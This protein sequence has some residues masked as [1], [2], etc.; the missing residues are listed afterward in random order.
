MKERTLPRKP[1]ILSES[2]ERRLGTYGLAASAAGVTA[3]ALAVPAADAKIV[4]TQT[5]VQLQDNQPLALDFNHDGKTDFFLLFKGPRGSVGGFYYEYLAACHRPITATHGYECL[6]SAS[7]TYNPLNGIRV[8]KTGFFTANAILAGKG[9]QKGE[10]FKDKVAVGMGGVNW[11]ISFT[12]GRT[13]WAGPWVNGGKG[14]KNRYLGVKFQIKG[15]SHFAWARLTVTTTPPHDFKATLTGYAYETI[16]GKAIIAGQTKGSDDADD[17]FGQ[18]NPTSQTM[19]T[20]EPATLGAL[21]IGAPA[22]SIWRRKETSL[23]G[24]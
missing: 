7:S 17:S 20:P 16:P 10:R 22:L 23:D 1:V 14:V 13:E 11:E 18:P 21:A 15:R 2:T 12:T 6:S 24:Q 19:P 4:Y 9:I 3:L 8:N 5:H